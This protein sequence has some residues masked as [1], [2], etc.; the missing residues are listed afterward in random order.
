MKKLW[1]LCACLALSIS[2]ESCKRKKYT[3]VVEVPLPTTQEKVTI[4]TPDDV[5]AESGA[6]EVTKLGYKYDD[7]AP[8]IDA[9]TMEIHYSKHYVTYT[10]ALNNL[11]K[12]TEQ[13]NIPIE[14]IYKK[15]DLNNNELKNNLGG[16][17]NHTL[18]F[19]IL[20]CKSNEKPS[21]T[22]T[23]SINKNFGSLESF[24]TQFE[25]AANKVFGS[26]WAWLVV[27]KSGQL[28]ITTTQNQDNPLLSNATVKG[29][30]ILG[31]D[32]W[33]HAY[34][35]NYQYRRKKYIEAFFKVINWKKVSEKYD[36]A[37]KTSP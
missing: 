27:S 4:G 1:I 21:D 14:D 6:F 5:K 34:Y 8:H 7:L 30:P 35:L 16:Y 9:M 32:L 36:E 15:L 25:D 3:E 17:Y 29:I 20:G 26:G 2:L 22:L 37:L 12:G 33:E 13:E 11:L 19:D 28:S 24:K 10:N 31:I 18:F 23:S